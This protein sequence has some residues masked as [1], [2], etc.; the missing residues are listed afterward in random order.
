[1][2]EHVGVG[3]TFQPFFEG[4]FNATQDQGPPFDQAVG[5]VSEADSWG[6][7]SGAGGQRSLVR[8]RER[9]MDNRR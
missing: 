3:V 6:Q 1:V 4:D 8:H 9:M 7:W 2:Q 5:V